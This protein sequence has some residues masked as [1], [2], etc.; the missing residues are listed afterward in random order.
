V[1]SS[2][3]S[4]SESLSDSSLLDSVLLVSSG[5]SVAIGG[6]NGALISTALERGGGMVAFVSVIFDSQQTDF[7]SLFQTLVFLLV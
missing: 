5:L 3:L 2:P 1:S 6:G 4:D 7:D